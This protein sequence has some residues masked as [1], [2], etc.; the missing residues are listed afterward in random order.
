MNVALHFL[1]FDLGG[2]SAVSTVLHWFAFA[3][4]LAI[5]PSLSVGII[6]KTKA[7][8]QNRRGAPIYQ[9][10]LDLYKFSVKGEVLSSL[11][12]WIFRTSAG[13]QLAI[14]LII[15][16]L[17]PWTN[18]KPSIE[19]GDLFLVVYL[20]AMV[21]MVAVLASLD[22]GSVFCGFG[23]SREVTMA[24][25][26]EPVSVLC[27][28]SLAAIGHTSD[29]SQI[30]TFSASSLHNET[31]LWI[32]CGAGLFM[33]SIV[34]L[35][36]MPVDDPCTHLE[37]T[38]IH[39]AMI[40]ENSGRNLGLIDYAHSLKL[41]I[42]MGLASQC[43]LHALPFMWE[44]NILVQ[45]GVSILGLI[46]MILL[47]ALSEAI[48]VKVRWTQIPQYVAYAVV[49]SIACAFVAIWRA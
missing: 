12:S 47:I 43:F 30:F 42:L 20:F 3:I 16:V 24:V 28:S 31:P 27:L 19:G 7:R 41:V 32:L 26:V 33:A 17:T 49:I 46:A 14:T 13:L 48:F 8:F 4:Y 37:L 15:A 10:L 2:G 45:C 25:L 29:L 34:E 44:S 18:L 40:I 22:A 36:R 6:R 23:A 35:S 11:A 39:E 1:G 21:R 5:M 9:P 38:M